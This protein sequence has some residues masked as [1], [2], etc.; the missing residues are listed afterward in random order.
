MLAAGVHQLIGLAIVI[1][2][3]SLYGTCPGVSLAGGSRKGSAPGDRRSL[4]ALAPGALDRLQAID[5][6]RPLIAPLHRLGR[7][8]AGDRRGGETEATLAYLSE[9]EARSTGGASCARGRAEVASARWTARCRR[10]RRRW[11]PV[12][13]PVGAP[14]HPN[15][16][17]LRCRPGPY[18]LAAADV[19]TILGAIYLAVL[20]VLVFGS[21][22]RTVR[23]PHPRGAR[24]RRCDVRHVLRYFT[25]SRWRR[26]DCGFG[27]V[28]WKRAQTVPPGRIQAIRLSQPVVAQIRL[29]SPRRQR[30]RLQ[31]RLRAEQ[32]Q[33]SGA[34][35][36]P[37]GCHR[38]CRS[39][40]PVC[41]STT[42]RS[43]RLHDALAQPVAGRY[44]AIRANDAVLSLPVAAELNRKLVV[45]PSADMSVRPHPGTAAA[46]LAAGVGARRCEPLARYPFGRSTATS[47]GHRRGT[48]RAGH[49]RPII[50]QARN[51]GWRLGDVINL[52]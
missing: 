30:R 44:L 46:H 50:R 52:G 43:S 23:P 7:A 33:H 6:V 22:R 2:I 8:A 25:T 32:G 51:A 41:R 39:C 18:S 34:R 31:R 29:G 3:G 21:R 5:I 1:P 20:V 45:A 48:G 10:R 17:S 42:F 19:G 35:G 47:L 36:A 9:K 13:M 40:F 4:S 16:S 49:R 12:A 11:P 38:A 15:E 28:C 14:E 26:N 37:T 27:T 24:R